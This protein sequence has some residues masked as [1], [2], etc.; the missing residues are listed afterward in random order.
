MH[1]AECLQEV[2][3]GLCFFSLRSILF[4]Y[5]LLFFFSF[6]FEWL[7][8][9]VSACSPSVK[10]YILVFNGKSYAVFAHW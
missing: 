5:F 6:P 4:E 9:F 2:K 8:G 7:V 1:R 3:C 10:E